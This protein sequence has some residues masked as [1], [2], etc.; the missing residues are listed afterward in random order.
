M[1][2]S[3]R[4][5][6]KETLQAALSKKIG[7]P[8]SLRWM[9]INDGS[10]WQKGRNTVDDPRA[11]H[12][13]CAAVHSHYV[14]SKIRQLY[15]SNKKKFPLHIRLG[16]IPAITKPMDMKSVAKFRVLMNRQE[17][18]SKQHMA[19][20]REDIVEID[21]EC[22]GSNKTLRDLIMSIKGNESDTPLFAS[23]DRKSNGQ[24]FNFSFHPDKL[25][26]ASMTIHGLF[27]RLAYKHG[28]EAIHHFFTPRAVVEGRRMMYDPNTGTVT[29][30]AD[31][32]IAKLDEIDL[33]MV[34]KQDDNKP[35]FGEWQ[36]FVKE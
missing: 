21:M 33:D 15:G 6:D 22:P 17:G 8:L 34:V 1:L 11:L 10:P 31:E 36:V 16:F 23:V 5:M 35:S 9:R 30:E 20:S 4:N 13:E 29:T 14:E 25:I 24:G 32:S 18:W 2:Y 7:T 3:T 27:P 19:R 12:I 28:E 26:E